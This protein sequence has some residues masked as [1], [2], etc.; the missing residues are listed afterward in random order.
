M[1]LTAAEREQLTSAARSRTV[2]AADARRAKLILMLEDG[3]SRY[4]HEPA[5]VR[6]PLHLSVVEALPE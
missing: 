5:G 1:N 6:L 4:D 2:R 3:E